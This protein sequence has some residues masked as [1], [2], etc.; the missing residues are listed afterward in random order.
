MQRLGLD[1]VHMMLS[2][3]VPHKR[4]PSMTYGRTLAKALDVFDIDQA[5]WPALAADRAAWRATLQSGQPPPAFRARPPTPAALPLAYT[6]A[7]RST[8]AAT[9]A[10]IDRSVTSPTPSEEACHLSLLDHI[11]P[12]CLSDLHLVLTQ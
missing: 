3:W 4:P 1:A 8:T 12:P 10:A 9:N 2:S 11:L 5:K 7:R 6:R